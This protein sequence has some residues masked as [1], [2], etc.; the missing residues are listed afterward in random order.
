[1]VLALMSGGKVS[2]ACHPAIQARGYYMYELVENDYTQDCKA[3]SVA[4]YKHK[5]QIR[6][7]YSANS[8]ASYH[9]RLKTILTCNTAN[10]PL[11]PTVRIIP[12]VLLELRLLQETSLGLFFF[13][14]FFFCCCFFF[15]LELPAS[16]SSIRKISKRESITR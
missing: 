14:C 9:W 6:H 4:N 10:Q 11:D 7:F 12:N 15:S 8:T 3:P 16:A 13:V 2:L 1:M 5:I